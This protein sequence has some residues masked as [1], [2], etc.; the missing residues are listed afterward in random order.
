MSTDL[1]TDIDAFGASSVNFFSSS[2]GK[3]ES[4]A[5]LMS[6]IEKKIFFL[7]FV[8]Q[9]CVKIFFIFSLIL[10]LLKITM[11]NNFFPMNI[12]RYRIFITNTN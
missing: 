8:C 10:C 6:G 3:P 4:G 5:I 7:P 9:K 2:S 12:F 11:E 1:L